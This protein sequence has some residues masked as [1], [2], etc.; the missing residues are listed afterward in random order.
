MVR[1][2]LIV[3]DS[4]AK[5]RNVED[6]VRRSGNDAQEIVRAS[7]VVDAEALV[8]VG[9]WQLIVLDISMNIVATSRGGSG[10]HATLGGIGLLERMYHLDILAP[11]VIVTAFDA[12]E[13]RE[14]T[15]AK[16]AIVDLNYIRE[17]AGHILGDKFLGCI[18]YPTPGWEGELSQAVAAT[19]TPK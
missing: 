8:E 16:G 4:D 14:N 5:Y 2:I 19:G 1:R 13:A 11:T 12:F 9:E 7:S 6:V 17:S 18:R 15:G 3:E 10:G